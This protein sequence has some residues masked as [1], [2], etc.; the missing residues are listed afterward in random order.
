M[1]T[2][3]NLIYYRVDDKIYELTVTNAAGA[4]VNITD[5]KLWFTVKTAKTDADA[6]ALVRKRSLNAGGA[7]AQ[8]KVTNG[9]GGV[10]RFYVKPADTAAIPEGTYYHDFQLRLDV[11]DL[12]KTAVYGAYIIVGD[13]TETI[14]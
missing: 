10:A 14:V 1:P 7:D 9:P 3:T 2:L 13:I 8:A 6:A 11:S 4:P 5:A 12:V